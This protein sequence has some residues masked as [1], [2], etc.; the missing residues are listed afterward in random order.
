MAGECRHGSCRGEHLAM[1]VEGVFV[2]DGRLLL[3]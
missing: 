2:K 1:S 3:V